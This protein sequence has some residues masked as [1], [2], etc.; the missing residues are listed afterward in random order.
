MCAYGE[1]TLNALQGFA[2]C[3]KHGGGKKCT[4]AECTTNAYIRG[5]CGKHGGVRIC[6]IVGCTNQQQRNNV[7]ARHGANK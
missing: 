6:K 7:C 1:C 2:N 5:L 3:A 4:V